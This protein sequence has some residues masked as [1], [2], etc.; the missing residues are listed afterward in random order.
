MTATINSHICLV[1]TKYGR[2]KNYIL[3]DLTGREI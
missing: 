3:Q 2:Q 1:F